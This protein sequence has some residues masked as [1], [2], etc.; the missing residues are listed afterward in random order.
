MSIVRKHENIPKEEIL[1]F[2]ITP[3]IISE[4]AQELK[5]NWEKQSKKSIQYLLSI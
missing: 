4:Y 1:N 2:T 5:Q 3:E